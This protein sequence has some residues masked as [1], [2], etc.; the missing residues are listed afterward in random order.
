MSVFT[1]SL[2]AHSLHLH[3][4][5]RHLTWDGVERGLRVTLLALLV[6]LGGVLVVALARPH[7]PTLLQRAEPAAAA[8]DWRPV[9]ELPR[10]W[11]WAPPRVE[12]DGMFRQGA[13]PG[14]PES[15]FR[16]RR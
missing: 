8:A 14:E 13:V 9:R 4:P 1:R 11:R 15:M 6:V 12:V 2:R 3:P 7:V 10:E 16:Q 5:A